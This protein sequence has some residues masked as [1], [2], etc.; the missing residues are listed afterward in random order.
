VNIAYSVSV[1]KSRSTVLS[2]KLPLYL[3]VRIEVFTAVF[4]LKM[5]AEWGVLQK[6]GILSHLYTA[7]QSRR[8]GIETSRRVNIS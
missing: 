7:T 1:R 4:T 2:E 3:G 6:V 5:E 8:P